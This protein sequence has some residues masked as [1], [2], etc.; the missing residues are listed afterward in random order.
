MTSSKKARD[1][2]VLKTFVKVHLDEMIPSH[3]R[4]HL[5]QLTRTKCES[6]WLYLGIDAHALAA[7]SPSALYIIADVQGLAHAQF[8]DT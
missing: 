5:A 2:T 8:M 4:W 1:Q 6:G 7:I 3:P